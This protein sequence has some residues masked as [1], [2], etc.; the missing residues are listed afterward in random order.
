[1][2][3]YVVSTG[4][5]APAAVAVWQRDCYG[6][7]KALGNIVP[8]ETGIWRRRDIREKQ[9]ASAY[10]MCRVEMSCDVLCCACSLCWVVCVL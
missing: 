8:P 6:A 2:V 9:T 4:V 10:S 7:G 1:M 5:V 3:K